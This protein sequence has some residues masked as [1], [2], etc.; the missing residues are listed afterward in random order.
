MTI[1]NNQQNKYTSYSKSSSSLLLREALTSQVQ[2]KPTNRQAN[3][4]TLKQQFTRFLS[5]DQFQLEKSKLN[6]LLNI[7][8]TT[9]SNH[10]DNIPIRNYRVLNLTWSNLNSTG[11][12]EDLPSY[13]LSNDFK[14]ACIHPYCSGCFET[15]AIRTNQSLKRNC[16]TYWEI[17]LKDYICS[18]TSVMIGI[19]TKEA[20]LASNGYLNLIGMDKNSWGL[21]NKGHLW[22]D[23]ISKSFCDSFDDDK[24]CGRDIRI[25][26]L[27]DGYSGRVAY[28]KD[29]NCIGVAFM[30]LPV[31]MELYPM[32]SSTVAKS[33][34]KL[35]RAFESFPSL[36]E[37]ARAKCVQNQLPKFL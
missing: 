29:G 6:D 22:H 8:P 5:T 25:G 20:I 32:V 7:Y 27:Y 17:S 35:E 34:I 23:N 19:G 14:S 15:Y 26:C 9:T 37:L 2:F 10:F 28:F 31:E 21:S 18:G 24:H 16:L 13:I 30:N 12:H 36:K 11:I 3:F 1:F 4:L 33:I